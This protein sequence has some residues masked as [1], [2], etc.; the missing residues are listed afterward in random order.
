[1]MIHNRINL[2]HFHSS[3]VLVGFVDCH[4]QKPT[5]SPTSINQPYILKFC[6][7][8]SYSIYYI[9][10]FLQK[11]KKKDYIHLFRMDLSHFILPYLN[12]NYVNVII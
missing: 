3:I 1:M 4:Q 9:Y 8:I 11:K 5:S 12:L 2:N 6:S 10:F 7:T